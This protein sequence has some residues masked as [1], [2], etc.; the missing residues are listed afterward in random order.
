ML[1][2][3]IVLAK[4]DQGSSS[5]SKTHMSVSDKY[6]KSVNAQSTTDVAD[7]NTSEFINE[8]TDQKANANAGSNDNKSKYSN[9]IN[10]QFDGILLVAN[11]QTTC[12]V[13]LAN[14]AYG[15]VA[16][17][18]VV[19]SNTKQPMD[20]AQ[21]GVAFYGPE[22]STSF[23]VSK[24]TVHPS[25]DMKTLANN[26]AVLEIHQQ[27]TMTKRT[28]NNNNKDSP[29]MSQISDSITNWDYLSY[30]RR[31]MASVSKHIWAP[32]QVKEGPVNNAD[33]VCNAGSSIYAANTDAFICSN[34]AAP[35]LQSA[36]TS[37][38]IP[39]AMVYGTL[40]STTAA[41]LAIYSH[42]AVFGSGICSANAQRHYFTLLGNYLAWGAST[43][44][45]TQTG[46]T[47]ST[48]NSNS[49]DPTSDNSSSDQV[50][51]PNGT[52]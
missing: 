51:D 21:L 46:P 52:E 48:S 6:S 33:S 47:K 32:V 34:L 23:A 49:V 2:F 11:E 45:Q 22:I 7:Q 17:T 26:I 18:C 10:S 3:A 31:S 5:S 25:F 44:A 19:D 50:D 39:L 20:K 28:N 36:D 30:I 41:P 42:S 35:A 15:Y 9:L 16:A 24:V 37:C 40:K 4:E 14:E 29:K 43:A 12:A 27:G 8:K 13:V 1:I 38:N